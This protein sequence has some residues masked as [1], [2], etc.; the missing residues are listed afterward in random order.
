MN[1]QQTPRT[2]HSPR[3]SQSF[4]RNSS[5]RNGGGYRGGNAGGRG[6]SGGGGYRGGNSGG[7]SSGGRGRSG[8]GYK[9]SF[10]NPD[11]FIKKA[12]ELV[13]TKPY[14]AT[15]TF[16]EF[17]FTDQLANAI[18]SRNY[19]IPTQI[20]DET[21]PLVLE[22][23]DVV[24][25]S[26]TGTGKTAAFL[27]PLINRAILNKRE[28]VIILAPTRELAVQIEDELLQITQNKLGVFSAICVGGANIHRQMTRLRKHNQFIIGTPG[29]IMDL[30]KRRAI[31]LENTRTIVLD[32]ADR[33]LDMGFITDMKFIMSHMPKE[34]QTLFFSAT[35]GPKIKELVK[36]FL[37][38]PI[39][40]SV[41]K[42]DASKN[43][44]QDVVR[45][46]GRDK[47]ELLKDLLA[48]EDL[49]KILIFGRTK[50]GVDEL[51][52]DISAW[53]HRADCLHGNKSHP[54]R[55]RAVK[56]FKAGD[57]SIL[58]ATDV[59]ARGIDINGITHVINYELPDSYE[60]Y[61][62]RIGRTGRAG[63]TGKALTFINR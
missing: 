61:I 63:K 14:E 21:I 1:N 33:M 9:M 32:E 4:S 60:D 6:R 41:I 27:L 12:E 55:E 54:Q 62:H 46:D 49:E 37:N 8:G 36:D 15:H 51:T 10:F 28:Q 5:N 7:R 23:R 11:M 24:G 17:G 45:I 42:S 35:M 43:V 29:R 34:R 39:T 47:K 13:A 38:D 3:G 50:H 53:G 40:V 18:A 26:N 56:R 31:S 57:V 25:L 58:V 44:D 22:G 19:T 52:R 48:Q 30:M 16:S 2:G 59:A 20:Q